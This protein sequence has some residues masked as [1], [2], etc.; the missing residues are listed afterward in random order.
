MIFFR[1]S[2]CQ[3]AWPLQANTLRGEGGERGKGNTKEKGRIEKRGHRGDSDK[4]QDGQEEE[5]KLKLL[6]KGKECFFIFAFCFDLSHCENGREFYNSRV[7]KW[8][9]KWGRVFILCP[10]NL[11]GGKKTC[12]VSLVKTDLTYLTLI[13]WDFFNFVFDNQSLFVHIILIVVNAIQSQCSSL[14][15][16]FFQSLSCILF[17]VVHPRKRE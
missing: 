8:S 1:W 4:E 13:I 9:C 10:G 3:A 7:D 5:A 2:S 16:H 6:Y 14:K 17:S 11:E 15:P 12:G